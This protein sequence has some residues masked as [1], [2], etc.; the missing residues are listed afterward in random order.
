M[1]LRN[2]IGSHGFMQVP[3]ELGRTM[4][5]SKRKDRKEEQIRATIICD[6][7][8]AEVEYDPENQSQKEMFFVLQ[9]L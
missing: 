5:N 6:E 4:A 3:H 2:A 8:Y 9:R 1:V 7:S